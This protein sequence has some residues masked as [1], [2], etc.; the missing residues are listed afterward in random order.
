MYK[1]FVEEILDGLA[2][3]ESVS[4]VCRGWPKSFEKLP[5]VAVSEA[6]NS[7]AAFIGDKPY[8][9]IAE[10]YVRIFTEKATEGDRAAVEVDET[11]RK[12]GFTLTFAYEDDNP[13]IR[14][15]IMRYETSY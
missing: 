11:M 6:A 9:N 2:L 12:L 4:S 15:K 8:I 14:Q 5:C 13:D 3:C 1:N 10:Y 7:T